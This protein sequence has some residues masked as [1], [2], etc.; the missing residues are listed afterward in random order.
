[1]KR[2]PF[3][4][5]ALLILSQSVFAQNQV[6]KIRAEFLRPDSKTI[7]VAAHRALHSTFPE[8]SLAAIQA[9]ID[10]KVDIVEIDVQ[11]SKD[12][13]PMLMHDQKMDRTT[14]GIG[15]LEEVVYEDLRKLR[16][17]VN[18]SLTEHQIPT[19]EEALRL[20]KGKIMVDLDLKTDRI[21]PVIEVVKKTGSDNNAFFFD[22]NYAML[23]KV[24]SASKNFMLMPRAYNEAMAD[25]ALRLYHPEVIHIDS[26]FYTAQVTGLIKKGNARIWI[27]ALGK[28][29]EQIRAGKEDA[30]IQ[31]LISKGANIIQTDEPE[32]ILHYLRSKHLHD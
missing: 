10:K 31:E 29:D 22:S 1:M 3:A 6:E 30:A 11:V 23:S 21:G 32:K 4:V 13:I 8:N 17:K 9:A 27:N 28:P 5:I 16:L 15:S 26:K 25:S 19:L 18:G 14:N 24:D 20:A 7:L 2:L 12:G